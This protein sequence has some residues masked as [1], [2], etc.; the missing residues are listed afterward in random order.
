MSEVAPTGL[1]GANFHVIERAR[2]QEMV[3]GP[4]EAENSRRFTA[5]KELRASATRI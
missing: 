4:R 5:S 2:W 3:G 1:E